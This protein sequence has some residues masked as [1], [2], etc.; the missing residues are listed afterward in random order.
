MNT[1][2]YH[3]EASFKRGKT[4]ALPGVGRATPLRGARLR[5]RLPQSRTAIFERFHTSTQNGD[6]TA[7]FWNR[8]HFSVSWRTLYAG[9]PLNE[10]WKRKA[11]AE[12]SETA[13]PQ[14]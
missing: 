13:A 1:M 8:Q 12:R 10:I 5:P 7:I 14:P 4:A 6:R 3:G 9:F 2:Y 11:P